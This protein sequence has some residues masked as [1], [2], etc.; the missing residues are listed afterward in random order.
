MT[1]ELELYQDRKGE[2]RFRLKI[3]NDKNIA[4]PESSKPKHHAVSCIKSVK[5][6]LQKVLVTNY[7]H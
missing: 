7:K 2:Y 1:T 3:E 4:K 5:K 6:M